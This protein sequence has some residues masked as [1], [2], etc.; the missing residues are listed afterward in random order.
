MSHFSAKLSLLGLV[1]LVV[2][3]SCASGG[4]TQPVV[5]T[6][7]REVLAGITWG[8]P[9]SEPTVIN[10]LPEVTAD[11]NKGDAG[12][13]FSLLTKLEL[14]FGDGG[15]WIDESAWYAT[16][17]STPITHVYPAPGTYEFNVRAI[18]WDGEVVYYG[19]AGQ[20]AHP[21]AITVPAT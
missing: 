14:D 18:Y 10:V 20:A 2:F 13:A 4:G 17:H 21:L 19:F 6:Y 11:Q 8:D 1:A 15:G 7:E 16:D 12:H 3:A 9:T 5:V